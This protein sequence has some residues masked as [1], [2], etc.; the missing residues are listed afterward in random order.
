MSKKLQNE[1]QY[2]NDIH[3]YRSF[4]GDGKNALPKE[5]VKEIKANIPLGVSHPIV[6]THPETKKPA[7]FYIVAFFVMTHSSIYALENQ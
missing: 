7:L 4:L 6:R 2:L 3:D 5:R 1:I